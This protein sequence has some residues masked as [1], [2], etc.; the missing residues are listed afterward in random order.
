MSDNS[1]FLWERVQNSSEGDI[2]SSQPCPWDHHLGY[3]DIPYPT[4]SMVS[5]PISTNDKMRSDKT[6]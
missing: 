4:S 2:P 1:I 3:S 6:K 5:L